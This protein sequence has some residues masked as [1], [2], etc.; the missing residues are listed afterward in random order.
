MAKTTRNDSEAIPAVAL[1]AGYHALMRAMAQDEMAAAD[2]KTAL[3]IPPPQ[4]ELPKNRLRGCGSH[5][6]PVPGLEYIAHGDPQGVLRLRQHEYIIADTPPQPVEVL[7]GMNAEVL[8]VILP[9]LSRINRF[10]EWSYVAVADG[11]KSCKR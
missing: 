9:P 6:L 7:D 4:D 5:L 1:T 8:I 3:V 11:W 10:Y 2:H